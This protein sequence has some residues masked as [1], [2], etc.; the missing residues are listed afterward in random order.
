MDDLIRKLRKQAGHFAA[1]HRVKFGGTVLDRHRE[2]YLEWRAADALEQAAAENK[3]L[4]KQ[5]ADVASYESA[6][7]RKR[8]EQLEAALA[9]M[10][11]AH[12]SD[13]PYNQ[14]TLHHL[15]VAFDLVETAGHT[16]S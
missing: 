15:R 8:I 13:R 14:I 11:K 2:R 1:E 9:P 3:R 12:K 7:Q 4:T 16:K 6:A 10:V 5:L